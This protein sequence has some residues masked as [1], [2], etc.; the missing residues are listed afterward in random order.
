MRL[1]TIVLER[2]YS[3][4][5]MN[6]RS[7]QKMVS[8]GM[9]KIPGDANNELDHP[10]TM[11]ELREAV[12][13]GK[14]HK[15][16]G[17]DG[18]CHEFFKQMWDVIKNIM[19]DIIKNMYMEGAVSDAHKHGHIVCLLKTVAPVS[20]ENYRPLTMLNIDYKLLTRIVA[21]RL[22]PWMEDILHR[23]QYCGRNGQTI[24]DAVATVRDI[25]AYAEETNKP[26]CLLSIDFKEAFDKMSHSFLFKILREYGI[27]DNFCSRLQ[28]IYADATCPIHTNTK[29][30]QVETGQY[31]EWSATKIPPQY[32]TIRLMHK[33][34]V[35]K[36][37]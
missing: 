19:L 12:N 7:F 34:S 6:K 24:F 32:V 14:R 25:I 21:N 33:S 10:I 28:K 8:C 1:F 5:Q 11:E 20:P 35:N 31:T 37:R 18:I 27:G 16:P 3:H 36:P 17:P 23:N 4:H 9:P 22:R 2:K 26:I 29:W 15:S 13:K 30:P